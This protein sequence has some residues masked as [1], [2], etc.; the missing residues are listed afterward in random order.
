MKIFKQRLI[1]IYLQ[2]WKAEVNLTTDGRLY[3]QFNKQFIFESYLKINN[4]SLRIA[5][6]KIR[7][8]SHLFFVERGRW[9]QRKIERRDR[10]CQFCNCIEDEFHVL[11]YCPMFNNTR[12]GL[13]PKYL[14]ENKNIVQFLK[15]INTKNQDEQKL[16]GL[17]CY[18]IQ[19]EYKQ[20][21]L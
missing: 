14:K 4:A 9:G 15:F 8:S 5:I 21:L 11:L 20:T 19:K 1:D 17:L 3:K 10:L 2:D 7:L 18:K 12:E 13:L 16:L 6:S